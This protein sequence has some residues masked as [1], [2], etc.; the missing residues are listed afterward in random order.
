[1]RGEFERLLARVLADGEERADRTGTGTRSLFAP[2]QLEYDLRAG[3]VP[4]LTSKRVAW[5]MATRE[6]MWMLRGSTDVRDIRDPRMTAIWE[7]WADEDHDVGP[8][9]GAQWRDSGGTLAAKA[10]E[11][12]YDIPSPTGVDQLARVLSL[13]ER[14][15]DTRRAVV[16]LWGASE[17]DAMGIEPCMVLFQFSRRGEAYERLE[18][19]VYQRSADMMLGVPFDLYQAGLLAHLVVREL[20]LRGQRVEATRLVWQAGDVHVYANQLD[21]AARQLRQAGRAGPMTAMVGVDP[22]PTLNLLDGTLEAG[23]VHVL[24][25]NPED[26]VDAGAPAV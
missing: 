7:A 5:K 19:S 10:A 1:V 22:Y 2:P 14:T 12:S 17:L 11:N 16:S 9:Y 25:Y 4:L 24:G 13:L 3:R 15:P 18:L 8:T 26:P 23:H 6:L 20:R 21:A